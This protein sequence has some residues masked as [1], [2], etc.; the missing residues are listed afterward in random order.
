MS[1]DQTL[2][3]PD[4]AV[5]TNQDGATKILSE[6]TNSDIAGINNRTQMTADSAA[7]LASAQLPDLQISGLDSTAKSGVTT[8]APQDNPVA[9][10]FH[11]VGTV[12]SDVGKGMFNEVTQHPLEVLE[13]G[14]VGLGIGIAATAAA[15]FL[16]PEVITVGVVVG[17]AYGISQL[18]E[19]VPGFVHDALVVSNAEDYSAAEVAQAHS[20]IENVGKGTTLILAG[21]AGGLA[22]GLVSS[23][24]ES[25]VASYT[26]RAKPLA[27][28]SVEP[29]VAAPM[30]IEQSIEINQNFFRASQD[31]IVP[32]VKQL[33]QVKFE[34]AGPGGQLV[35]TLEN[36]AGVE[37]P[38]GQWIATRLN[39]DGTP[40]MERGM[41]NTWTPSEKAILKGYKLTPDELAQNSNIT[42]WTNTEAPPVHM[43]QLKEPIDIETAWGPMHG[44]AGSW[45]ANY[46]YNPATGAPGSSWAIVTEQSYAATYKPAV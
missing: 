7:M 14:A 43:V 34:K 3:R 28:E 39:A 37:V 38:E 22:S 26:Q 41:V 8:E 6:Q 36:P 12:A 31:E 21:T 2:T 9:D 24:V 27:V 29:V 1:S 10:F 23:S 42:G 4:S 45:L 5:S 30:T 40:N 16:A 18:V 25:T 11:D 19:H 46:D 33:Y 35:K 17:A 20:N 15:V 44:D 32:S 13:A